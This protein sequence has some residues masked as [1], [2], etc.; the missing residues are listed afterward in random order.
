MTVAV[1]R[2]RIDV[3]GTR[4]RLIQAGPADAAEAVVFVHGNP[5]SADDW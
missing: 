4:P 1:E 3:G 5:G 2:A